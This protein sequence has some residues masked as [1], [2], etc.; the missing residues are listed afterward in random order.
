MRNGP[1][2][3]DIAQET[4]LRLWKNLKKF[5]QSKN[6]KTW[7]FAIAKNASL[8]LL[9]KKK[10]DVVLADR[11]GGRCR[12]KPSSRPT[13]LF[14]IHQTTLSTAG[15]LKKNFDV[16]LAKLP[17][18]YR[19]VMVMRYTDNLKFREIAERLG[20]PVDTVKS[21][22]RRGL[23]LLRDMLDGG[24]LAANQLKS[25]RGTS[26]QL[27]ILVLHQKAPRNRIIGK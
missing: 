12:S 3:E 17:S 1:D 14:R 16:A 20:E 26:G 19:D 18:H 15:L 23:A 24:D 11:R 4:F 25:Q 2:A 21:R 27:P 5:D 6:F 10:T 9:K 7:L 22:H 8:D 13:S